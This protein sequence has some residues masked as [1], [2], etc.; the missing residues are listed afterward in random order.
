[1]GFDEREET[2]SLS[3][4]AAVRRGVYANLLGIRTSGKEAVLDFG[5]IDAE[6]MDDDGVPVRLGTVQARVIVTL[7]TLI[8]FRDAMS[9]HIDENIGEA[10]ERCE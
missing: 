3:A 2:I 8:E 5:F 6:S 10:G 1:M 4:D 9:L 7:D